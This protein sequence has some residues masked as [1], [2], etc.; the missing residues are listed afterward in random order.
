MKKALKGVSPLIATLLLIAVSLVVAGILY[1]W[2][3]VY[4]TA[5]TTQIEQSTVAQAACAFAGIDIDDSTTSSTRCDINVSNAFPDL[6]PRLTLKLSNTGTRDL[7]G[8]FTITVTDGNSVVT[9]LYTPNLQ[10]GSFVLVRCA[11]STTTVNGCKRT[12]TPADLNLMSTVTSMRVTSLDCPTR[13]DE[14]SNCRISQ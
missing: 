14:S 9:F 7:N 8:D 13:Y 12:S 6:Q 5:Q 4:F 11:N 10:V 3:T 2:S 1:T